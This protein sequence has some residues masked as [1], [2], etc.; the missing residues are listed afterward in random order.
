[1][2]VYFVSYTSSDT[3]HAQW[4]AQELHTLGH[5]AHVHEWEVGGGED[6]ADWMLKR[7]DTSDHVLCVISEAYLKAPYS[8]WERNAALWK[9]VKD[10]PGFVLLVVVKP[11][12]LP[13]MLGAFKRCELHGLPENDQR[14]RLREYIENPAPP[15]GHISL[16]VQVVAESNITIRVPR[17]FMGRDEAIGAIDR[18][19]TSP[20]G[21][22]A[23]TALHG[24]RGVGKTVLAVAYAEQQRHRYRAAWWVR[25]ENIST[26]RADL[27]DLGVRLG[28][29]AP[30][31][32]QEEALA[33]VMDHLQR[34]GDGILLIYDNAL[35]ARSLRPFLPRG[36]RARVL[37]TSNDHAWR[38]IAE[39]VEIRVWPP[40]I[41]A[42]FLRERCGRPNCRAAALALSKTLGGLP[43]A[44]EQA[45]AY[46]ERLED[47]FDD[48]R[49]RFEA[50]PIP[51]LDDTANAAEDYHDRR[52][53]ARTFSLAIEEA[54]KLHPAAEALIVHAALLA[55]EP[56]PRDLFRVV[57]SQPFAT[58]LA[59]DELSKAIAALRAFA[60]VES[61]VVPDERAPT[62]KANTIRLHRLVREVAAARCTGEKREDV[63]VDLLQAL[64]AMYPSALLLDSEAWPLA[65]RLDPLAMALANQFSDEQSGSAATALVWV[66][67]RLA[68]YRQSAHAAFEE[69]R[70]IFERAL[71][72]SKRA[73]G[74][75][76]PTTAMVH[77]DLGVLFHELGDFSKAQRHHRVA[78]YIREKNC[79]EN[80]PVVADSLNNLA[81]ALKK[82]G[83][84]SGALPLYQRALEIREY[85]FG[86]DHSKTANSLGNIAGLLESQGKY[87][88]ARP[89]YERALAIYLKV[90]GREHYRTAMMLNDLAF[91]LERFG[92]FALAANH[93][94]SALDIFHR[95]LGPDHP[96]TKMVAN[97]LATLGKQ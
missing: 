92:D 3:V 16:P 26:M 58:A 80:S 2:A 50:T 83:D 6:I 30:D 41:G 93:Y 20:Q 75:E 67:D 54:A 49:Q 21:R 64:A 10:R 35:D 45:A 81:L 77:N 95:I 82:T 84:F 22:V 12:A 38:E 8:S 47:S 24:M 55:A 7:F 48:Y 59:G 69:A 34:Q 60:L 70:A 36:G 15:L 52:T 18:A 27:V 85:H 23:I 57:P 68:T 72:V 46:C 76:H 61:E 66:L 90:Y 74:T 40:E 11:C 44:H 97:N 33:T 71:A 13:G 65:R 88:E 73:L 29:I 19:L 78:R 31:A 94:N 9:T 17:H 87:V 51:F 28:W 91:L 25:A 96:R 14:V 86:P 37:I 39:L 79:G 53:V 56:I 63:L 62:I 43:L 1:M 42:E 4:I 5:T 32:K 89:M